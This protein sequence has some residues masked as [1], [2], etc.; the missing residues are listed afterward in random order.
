MGHNQQLGAQGETLVHEFLESRGIRVLARNWRCK[1]GELD[2]IAEDAGTVVAIEVKTR[3]GVGYGHPAE[4]VNRVKLGRIHRL[5]T[6]WCIE[7]D[8]QRSPR[9][10][11]VAA[12][13][14]RPYG[15]PIVDYYEGLT[16]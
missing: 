13:T 14:M 5:I 2:I 16:A 11:D 1:H 3:N 4:A 7:N 8:R 10:I 12:I 15:A 9:R 6:V